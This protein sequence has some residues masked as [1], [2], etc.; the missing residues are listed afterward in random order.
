[1]AA[2]YAAARS[3]RSAS[4]RPSLPTASVIRLALPSKGRIHLRVARDAHR[5]VILR[6]HRVH[7]SACPAPLVGVAVGV[8]PMRCRSTA[9]A[10]PLSRPAPGRDGAPVCAF[11]TDDVATAGLAHAGAVLALEAAAGPGVAGPQIP[12]RSRCLRAT[13]ADTEP[14]RLAI[15][16]RPDTTKGHEAPEPDSCNL[17]CYW[18]PA[19]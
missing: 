11:V 5:N 16:V 15:G 8:R 1:M 4:V 2:Q 19:H 7:A 6:V 17:K 10:G 13:V 18:H 14:Q 3:Y 9:G 12:S